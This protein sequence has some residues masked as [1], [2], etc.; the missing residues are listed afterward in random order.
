MPGAVR[1]ALDGQID[2]QRRLGQTLDVKDGRMEVKA[3][4]NGGLKMTRQGLVI[5]QEQVGEKNLSPC[6]LVRDLDSGA[7]AATIVEKVNELLKELRRT[8]RMRS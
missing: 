7:S 1:R 5:D 3:A 8:G 4:R 6:N 2:T